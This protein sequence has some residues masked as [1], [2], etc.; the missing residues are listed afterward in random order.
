MARFIAI[1]NVPGLT[2]EGFREKLDGVKQWRPDRRTTILKVYGDLANGK[3]VSECEAVEQSHFEGLDKP[4]GLA[5]RVHPQGGHDLPGG[6]FL[7][8][9]TPP[10]PYWPCPSYRP[11]PYPVVPAK[12]GIQ[13]TLTIGCVPCAKH[14]LDSGLRRNDGIGALASCYVRP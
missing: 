1:H 4:G 12:A 10:P 5:R 11:R 7:E 2:E 13:K 9:L 3:L 8:P 14:F 6:E